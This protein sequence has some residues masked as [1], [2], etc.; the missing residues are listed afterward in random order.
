MY[1]EKSNFRNAKRNNL[2]S[3]GAWENQLPVIMIIGRTRCTT[4]IPSQD[5]TEE[6]S[7]PTLFLSAARQNSL[8]FTH[9]RVTHVGET[10]VPEHRHYELTVPASNPSRRNIS[11]SHFQRR[12]VFLFFFFFFFWKLTPLGLLVMQAAILER[13]AANSLERLSATP[14]QTKIKNSFQSSATLLANIWCEKKKRERENTHARTHACTH[15]HTH[16]NTHTHTVT[17]KHTH[18][19]THTHTQKKNALSTT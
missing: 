5:E 4:M 9:H 13:V 8:F 10:Q 3:C 12:L 16:T 6:S 15:T 7:A 19:H 1:D 11:P 17:H 14:K 2:A 18:T